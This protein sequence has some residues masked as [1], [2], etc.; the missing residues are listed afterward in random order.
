MAHKTNSR[1]YKKHARAAQKTIQTWINK[2]SFNNFHQAALFAAEE[3][4]MSGDTEKARELFNSGIVLAARCGFL[5]NAALIN[6]RYAEFFLNNLQDK[7]QAK[8]HVEQ[9]IKFFKAW[10]AQLSVDKIQ[11]KYKG[12]FPAPTHLSSTLSVID[13]KASS[14]GFDFSSGKMNESGVR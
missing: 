6:E 9:A 8:Y 4:A 5:R 2:G 7:E 10:G 13:I 14:M 12:L 1:K 11:S 3:A